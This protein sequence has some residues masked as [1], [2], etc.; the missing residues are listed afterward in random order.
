MAVYQ[1]VS[2]DWRQNDRI[3]STYFAVY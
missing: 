1:S 3:T 2:L